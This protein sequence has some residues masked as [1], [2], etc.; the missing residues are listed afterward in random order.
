MPENAP[1]RVA[2]VGYTNAWPLLT[3]LDRIRYQVTERHPAQV[4]ELLASG[5]AD[6]GLVPV[7][8]MLSDGDYKV[9]PGWCIGAEGPVHSVLLVAETPP[10]EWTAVALDGV[11]RTSV[12]LSKLLL[13]EGPLSKRV[14]EGLEIFDCA[15]GKLSL[16]HI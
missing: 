6:V 4:A 16:I 10:E 13:T 2:A 8:A 3:R 11:S 7:A 9:I 14:P 12:A 5:Q 1:I 15:A